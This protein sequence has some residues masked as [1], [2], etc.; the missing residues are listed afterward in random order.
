MSLVEVT[1]MKIKTFKYTVS[2][3]FK[4]I[5]RN[6]V[7]SI[8]ST[9][10]VAASLLIL[11]L[12]FILIVNL[13]SITLGAQEQYDSIQIYLVEG[14]SDLEVKSLGD[15][16]KK[17]DSVKEIRYESKEDALKKMQD[18]WQQNGYLLEGLE[19][20]PLPNSFEVR[21]NDLNVVPQ[22]AET[23]KTL[24]G[25][26]D[27]KFYRDIIEKITNISKMIQNVGLVI[28][29]SLLFLSV[30]IINNTIKLAVNARRR[31]IN[32]MKYV[33][34]TN[35]FVRWPFFIE[36]TILGLMGSLVALT[37]VMGLYQYVYGIMASQFY[38]LIAAYIVSP[39]EIFKDLLLIF[40]VIGTG[41]GAL[42]SLMSM[43]K[44]LNV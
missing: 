43:R 42:G 44:Y 4:N 5:W 11:G 1:D 21:F 10:S 25:V 8:A 39:G 6:G 34:A 32:I 3:S 29:F 41:I 7:M 37:I 26:E 38:A 33:G 2:E 19:A 16:I 28:I 27:V 18:S 17:M 30:F 12:V 31:E 36:G 13:N 23:I 22:V 24:D 35:W 14:I 9:S 20:N 40:G 15:K